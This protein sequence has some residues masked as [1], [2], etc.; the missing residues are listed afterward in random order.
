MTGVQTCALP[1]WLGVVAPEL[2]NG[3]VAWIDARASGVKVGAIAVSVSIDLSRR[4][5]VVKRGTEVVRRVTIGVGAPGSPTPIG[6]FAV[7]DKLPGSRYGS[8]YGCCILALSARQ[9][10]LPL[11]WT[12]GDRIAVHGTDDPWTVGQATSAGCPHASADDLR[13]LMRILPLG[14]PVFIHP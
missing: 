11:G 8:Y 7:T 2:G 10:N 9:E 6:R 1:I 4:L 3:E 12:G 5:L 13:Y 14:T